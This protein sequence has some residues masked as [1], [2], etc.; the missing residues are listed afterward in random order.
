[1]VENLMLIDNLN[2]NCT[3]NN[4]TTFPDQNNET[5]SVTKSLMYPPDDSVS[6]TDN[7]NSTEAGG[8]LNLI[9]LICGIT[10][11]VLAFL[12][13]I[14]VF[15]VTWNDSRLRRPHNYYIVSLAL[16]DFLISVISMPIWTTYSALGK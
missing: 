10:M 1:M 14:I 15:I 2:F 7:G 4:F 3:Q 11:I 8:S 12:G 13:Q 9:P 6:E 16:A 5:E